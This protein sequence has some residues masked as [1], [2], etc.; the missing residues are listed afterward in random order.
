MIVVN[1]KR[2]KILDEKKINQINNLRLRSIQSC[3]TQ[4]SSRKTKSIMVWSKKKKLIDIVIIW[5]LILL[6]KSRYKSINRSIDWLRFLSIIYRSIKSI[7]LVLHQM[8]DDN[9]HMQIFIKDNFCFLFSCKTELSSSTEIIDQSINRLKKLN[10]NEKWN[11][12]NK[13]IITM[14]IFFSLY[15]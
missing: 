12:M 3:T 8:Y 9:D 6:Y 5:L 14:V 15:I 11:K 4:F 2:N 10:F 1:P 13:L 7:F